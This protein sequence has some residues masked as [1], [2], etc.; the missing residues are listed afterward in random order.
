MLLLRSNTFA[1]RKS[2]TFKNQGKI[3]VEGE[4]RGKKRD[5]EGKRRGKEVKKREKWGKR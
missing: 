5:K 2:V 1:L 4:K 3:K